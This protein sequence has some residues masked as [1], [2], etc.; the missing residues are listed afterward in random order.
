MAH[1]CNLCINHLE[2][3]IT[4]DC[5]SCNNK[6]NGRSN[7]VYPF[8]DNRKYSEKHEIELV[9]FI[10]N[11][12][13]SKFYAKRNEN[14]P[15]L[16]DKYNYLLPDI[17]VYYKENNNIAFYME[18][19]CE[20]RTFMQIQGDKYC[21]NGDIS[22]S[23]KVAANKSDFLRYFEF[24]KLPYEECRETFLRE[25]YP[26][27]SGV[28][29]KEPIYV[30]WLIEDRPCITKST[31]K[32]YYCYQEIRILNEIYHEYGDRR[33][34]TRNT[35][36]GDFNE[37]GEQKGVTGNYHYNINELEVGLPGRF[38]E[39]QDHYYFLTNHSGG[40]L[41]A[42]TEWDIIGRKYGIINH[43]H[44]WMTNKTSNG[45]REITKKDEIE[46]RKKCTIAARQMGRIEE[47][48]FVTNPRFI[49][50]WSQVKYS[51]AVFAITTILAV[52]GDMK[53][54][55]KAKIRQGKGG[56]G[57]A[58]QMAINE[59]KPVYIYDQKRKSWFSNIDGVWGFS[60]IPTLT[61]NFA[62]I[63][64]REINEYGK[65]AIEDVYK[66]FSKLIS[67]Y[68]YHEN[69]NQEHSNDIVCSRQT[70]Y[71]E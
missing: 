17:A 13:D 6:C 16:P 55:K 10:N 48:Q 41:G 33:F 28:T 34:Y 52:G 30:V 46:G 53:Y 64:T 7:G 20:K 1:T 62:G 36:I 60:E 21:P 22:P 35:G 65:Q 51:D 56:T 27:I 57:Y 5:G 25:T 45:N 67:N 66:K 61:R 8:E 37:S 49:R 38:L 11:L 70:L 15:L 54:E 3:I 23:E 44:Y 31:I 26:K 29:I 63:G 4:H 47:N 71:A 50:N 39:K 58:I 9:N 2:T 32:K 24:A 43:N 68:N 40:A 14:N 18:L 69:T 42:D 12:S 59:G 19:K